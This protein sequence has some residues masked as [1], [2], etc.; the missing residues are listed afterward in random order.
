MSIYSD[1]TENS[2]RVMSTELRDITTTENDSMDNKIG[3]SSDES[4]GT[5]AIAGIA[6]AA[7]VVVLVLVLIGFLV[8]VIR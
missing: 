5:G 2:N 8:L 1:S 3:G 7:A 4:L 6:A